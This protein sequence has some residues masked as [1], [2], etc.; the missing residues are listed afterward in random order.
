MQTATEQRVLPLF[1][2]LDVPK[3]PTELERRYQAMSSAEAAA[4]EL[5]REE[6]PKFILAY[7]ATHAEFS[8]EDTRQAYERDRSKP[9]PAK[10]QASGGI[11]MRL[12]KQGLLRIVDRKQSQK[13]GNF[14]TTYTKA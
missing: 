4:D 8:G 10:W 3:K 7:A 6:Y 9:Q 2:D 5:W 11:F 12:R 14:L 1:A 13:Y